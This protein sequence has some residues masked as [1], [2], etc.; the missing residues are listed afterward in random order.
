MTA[1]GAANGPEVASRS[2]R[3]LFCRYEDVS[4]GLMVKSPIKTKSTAS[5]EAGE[6]SQLRQ[7][8]KEVEARAATLADADAASTAAASAAVAQWQVLDKTVSSLQAAVRAKED[9]S[10]AATA[11]CRSLAETVSSLRA[12]EDALKE[13]AAEAASAEGRAAS[14]RKRFDELAGQLKGEHELRQREAARRTS[15]EAQLGDV[16]RERDAAVQAARTS[17]ESRHSVDERRSRQTEALQQALCRT[18]HLADATS[19]RADA[20]RDAVGDVADRIDRLGA[21]LATAGSLGDAES[22]YA[23]AA[24]LRGTVFGASNAQYAHSL[25][26]LATHCQTQHDF[27][28]A[29]DLLDRSCAAYVSSLQ[30]GERQ[31]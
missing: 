19:A 15:L 2:G 20:T 22:V 30:A 18:T 29:I 24:A 12:R 25:R 4:V 31:H 3:R 23:H 14:Y 1:E 28:S 10:Q 8:L 26:Q 7:R 9:A 13:R 5:K 11:Q 16:R 27:H 17:E 21:I 6:A